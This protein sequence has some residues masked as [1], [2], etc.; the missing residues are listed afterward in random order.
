M[1]GSTK[2]PAVV[3][4][5]KDVKITRLAL[6]K[7]AVRSRN[8]ITRGL[9]IRARSFISRRCRWNVTAKYFNSSIQRPPDNPIFR[10]FSRNQRSKVSLFNEIAAKYR[11]VSLCSCTKILPFS[12]WVQGFASFN[13]FRQSY[14]FDYTKSSKNYNNRRNTRPLNIF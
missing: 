13:T 7:L 6:S 10:R 1:V 11:L 8:Y 14:P 2:R 9:S 4:F 12:R 3:W 5:N